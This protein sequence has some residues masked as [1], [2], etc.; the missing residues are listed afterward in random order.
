MVVGEVGRTG[1]GGWW[2]GWSCSKQALPNAAT[3]GD[4]IKR[5][6]L[7]GSSRADWLAA[8]GVWAWWPC[9]Q[10]RVVPTQL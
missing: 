4:V 8:M 7:A 2:G 6:Q 5:S 1:G 3:A 10:A 9:T